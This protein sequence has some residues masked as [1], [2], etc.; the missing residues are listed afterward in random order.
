MSVK[1][2]EYFVAVFGNPEQGDPV[3]AGI[4]P[5]GE[6]Y[7]DF[8]ASIGDMLLLYCTENYKGHSK[9]VPG[10]GIVI[11]ASPKLIQYR[12]MPLDKPIHKTAIDQNFEPDDSQKMTE[13]RF[14]SRRLFEISKQSFTKTLADRTIAWKNM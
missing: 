9:E 4:Y 6:N 7:P 5:A 14:S 13:L 1:K 11:E 8:K 10:I 12:W 3:D 2:P